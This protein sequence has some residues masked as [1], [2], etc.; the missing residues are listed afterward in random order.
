MHKYKVI[1][2]VLT[3]GTKLPDHA[4]SNVES[5][6]L[7]P[8]FIGTFKVLK[9]SKDAYELDILTSMRLHPTFYFGRL[10][11]YLPATLHWLTPIMGS[12]I[13]N[14]TFSPVSLDAPMTSDAAA[15]PSVHSHEPGAPVSSSVR[16]ARGSTDGFHLQSYPPV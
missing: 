6:K 2:L 9:C 10:K 15:L 5:R 11:P 4:V 3:H 7:L 12:E 1:D 16:A 8:R 13:R 14:S